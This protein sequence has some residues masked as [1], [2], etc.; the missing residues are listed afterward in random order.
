MGTYLDVVHVPTNPMLYVGALLKQVL[1]GEKI[2]PGHLHQMQMVAKLR[3][4]T[5][6]EAIGC[7]PMVQAC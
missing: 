6:E 4:K 5:C 1:G 2:E 3:N 7:T